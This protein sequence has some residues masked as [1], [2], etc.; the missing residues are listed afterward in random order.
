MSTGE[1]VSFEPATGSELWRGRIGDAEDVVAR[2]RRAWPLWAAQP[3]STRIELLRRFANEVRKE[4]DKLADLI[5]RETGKPLWEARGEVDSVIDKV[6]VSVRAYAERTSQRKL[7]SALNGTSAVRHKPHGVLAVISP[8]NMPAL[9]PAA[10]IIPALIA[11]NVVVFQPSEKA[12]ATGELLVRCFHRGGISAAVVQVLQGGPEQAQTLAMHDGVDGVLFTGSAHA[13]VS[14][15]R[16]L[17]SNPGKVVALELG[18]NNPI[19]VW[20]TPKIVDAATIVV[21]SAFTSAGQRCS[22]ARRLIIKSTM[23]DAVIS[24]VRRLTERLI[25]GAPFDTPTPFMGPVIDNVAADGLTESF[26]YLLSNGGRAIKHMTRLREDLPFVSPAIIDVTKIDERPDVELFGPLLQVVAVDDFDEAIAE[27]NNTRF[28]L[29]ASLLG[30]S[31]QDYNRFWANARAGVVNWNRPT[32]GENAG[33][34][35]G[36]TGLSGN[37]RPGGYYMADSCAYPVASAEMEQP[38]ATIGVGLRD[39]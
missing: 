18:G 38:R 1:I 26:V 3:L 22:S 19:V 21:Q 12:P 2:A 8:Y 28:G 31:P 32:I 11:G 36:G 15:N 10:Q 27:A 7:D 17:A 25:V 37:N 6:E 5:A 14:I 30:G 4:S 24:E 29:V 16:K 13:G 35:F 9:L 23:Y 34:P 39:T 33:A 20:D